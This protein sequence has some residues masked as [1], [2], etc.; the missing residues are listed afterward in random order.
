M[1]DENVPDSKA[2]NASSTPEP[3][4]KKGQML[5]IYLPE[6]SVIVDRTEIDLAQ[7]P[8]IVAEATPGVITPV[9]PTVTSEPTPEVITERTPSVAA[10]IAPAKS[11]DS[12]GPD[13]MVP[14]VI[15]QITL[16]EIVQQAVKDA[17]GTTISP[18][19]TARP[20]RRPIAVEPYPQASRSNRHGPR[21]RLDWVHGVNIM[22][23]IY[24]LLVTSVPA[25]LSTAF[26]TT[27]YASKVTHTEVQIAAGD[28]M[29]TKQLQAS[30][31]KP[32]DVFLV[33]EGRSWRLDARLVKTNTTDGTHSTITTAVVGGSSVSPTYVFQNN[34]LTYEVTR[35][36]PKLGYVPIVLSST[37]VKVGGA[38]AILIFN[39]AFHYRRRHRRQGRNFV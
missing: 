27:M 33:R 7:T 18:T 12:N 17:L 36:I 23:V 37:I 30:Q 35:V 34:A 25:L 13:E 3:A 11:E 20:R 6:G 29:V 38:F 2:V 32:N 22:L 5:V 31:L 16:E 8:K 14:T 1:T 21:R 15:S 28:L 19:S 10:E 9:A 4:D 39:L 24:L 26:G